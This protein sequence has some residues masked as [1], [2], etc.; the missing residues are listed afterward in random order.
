MSQDE[1]LWSSAMKASRMVVSTS[2]MEEEQHHPTGGRTLMMTNRTLSPGKYASSSFPTFGR[3]IS[4]TED[5]DQNIQQQE[6]QEYESERLASHLMN[7]LVFMDDV[8]AECFSWNQS[9]RKHL[10]TPNHILKLGAVSIMNISKENQWIGE[11]RFQQ[12]LEMN[13]HYHLYISKNS[14]HHDPVTSSHQAE[15]KLSTKKLQ[16]DQN[17]DEEE[18]EFEKIF[19]DDEEE[20]EE[21]SLQIPSTKKTS[22][23]L[24]ASTTPPSQAVPYIVASDQL[25]MR[26]PSILVNSNL[27]KAVFFVSDLSKSLEKIVKKAIDI[28]KFTQVYFYCAFSEGF[29]EYYQ[30]TVLESIHQEQNYSP[31]V[32]VVKDYL[33][34]SD[35]IE[36][37]RL[38]IFEKQF[39]L[40]KKDSKVR[41]REDEINKTIHIEVNHYPFNISLLLPDIFM[42]P[43]CVDIFPIISITKKTS[44][45]LSKSNSLLSGFH[46]G[47]SPQKEKDSSIVMQF[48]DLPSLL[49]LQYKRV[50]VTL[51]DM[52][53]NLRMSVDVYSLGQTSNLIAEDL[54]S[55]IGEESFK[56]TDACTLV[57][58][59]RTLDL[60]SPMVHSDNILDKVVCSLERSSAVSNNVKDSSS[61]LINKSRSILKDSNLSGLLHH[62]NEKIIDLIRSSIEK[63]P[64]ETISEMKITLDK[65]QNIVSKKGD[66]SL[67][68]TISSLKSLL[69]NLSLPLM[70]QNGETIQFLSTILHS[71]EIIHNDTKYSELASTEKLILYECDTNQEELLKNVVDILKKDKT[72]FSSKEILRL[73]I[74]IY[75]VVSP[76]CTFSNEQELKCLLVDRIIEEY[77]QSHSNSSFVEFLNHVLSGKS[78]NLLK[79][80]EASNASDEKSETPQEEEELEDDNWDNWDEDFDDDKDQSKNSKS[81]TEL[82]QSLQNDLTHHFKNLNAIKKQRQYFQTLDKLAGNDNVFIFDSHS[83]NLGNTETSFRS[84]CKQLTYVMGEMDQCPDLVHNASLLSQL[85]NTFG[86]MFQSQ[87]AKLIRN[88]SSAI[89]IFVVGGITCGEIADIKDMIRLNIQEKGQNS[90]YFGKKVWIGSTQITTAENI[91]KQVLQ[92]SNS[93]RV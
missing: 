44:S 24:N 19:S 42:T 33:T 49:Q 12:L 3:G 63:K 92:L 93:A 39:S 82:S 18:E 48:K 31:R 37:T 22:Q 27:R 72:K 71:Q 58:M 20:E 8:Y 26:D 50:S 78:M 40:Q 1:K 64:S 81:Q 16:I 11:E 57:I 15:M 68:K 54:Q 55:L 25:P 60:V 76:Q 67:D 32:T 79:Q 89:I 73:V 62:G 56:T 4:D 35:L 5:Y 41:L 45:S 28:Y 70:I 51:R 86:F 52:L 91:M 47:S 84:M 21:Q 90:P 30:S 53:K 69:Q 59:D 65:L 80:S 83:G 88:E 43:T 7:A 36:K 46:L 23:I 77:K 10:L 14:G 38:F 74:M 2:T 34:Y 61:S 9:S 17:K 6:Q 29:C 75:S 85:T 87:K 66:M 13:Y